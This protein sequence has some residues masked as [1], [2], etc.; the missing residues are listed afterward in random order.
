[1]AFIEKSATSIP[2]AATSGLIAQALR[3]AITYGHIKAGTPLRQDHIAAEFG[4]SHIPVR[5]ALKELVTEGLAIFVKNR[6]VVV[7]ELSAD[8]AWELTEYRCLLEGQMARWAVPSMTSQDFAQAKDVLERLD[9]ET[10]IAEILRLN[11]AFHEVIYRRAD[12]PF[13][14]KSI[15]SARANLARYSRLAW[16]QLDHKPQSQ[17]EHRKIL[18]LCQRGDAETVATEIEGHI[19]ST[20]SLIV[21]YIRATQQREATHASAR[22]Q[23]ARSENNR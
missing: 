23:S 18:K 1:L 4:V 3:E 8:F 12:R 10:R 16:E 9:A 19:R 21:S 15:A 20:G 5:E 22:L 2:V 14:L 7:S 13:F 17:K 11:T 6:G